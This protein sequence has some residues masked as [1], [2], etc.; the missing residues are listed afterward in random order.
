MSDKKLIIDK[1]FK[2][3][4]K[5]QYGQYEFQGS[6]EFD[7]SIEIKLNYWL[8]VSGRIEAGSGIEAG[9][10]IK[11]GE[12]I[13]AGLTIKCQQIISFKCRLFAG[14]ALWK[15]TEKEEQIIEC[16]RI[17]GEVGYGEV[18]LLKEKQEAKK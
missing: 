17:D 9:E 15:K 1:D 14:I 10:G 2:G 7:G 6:I 11:A 16:K 3:L 4:V 12:G 5:N 8:I 13:E 18:R